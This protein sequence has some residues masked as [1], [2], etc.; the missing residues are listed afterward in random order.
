MSVAA[1]ASDGPG[2]PCDPPRQVALV[3]S[4][5]AYSSVVGLALVCAVTD[6]EKGYPFEVPLPGDARVNGVVLADRVSAVDVRAR[7]VRLICRVPDE[8]T[9]KVQERLLPLVG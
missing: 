3:V 8:V 5:A 4:P 9:R 6:T 7:G 1:E 2:G